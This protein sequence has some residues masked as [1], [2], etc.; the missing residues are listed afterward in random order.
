MAREIGN[1]AWMNLDDALIILRPENVEKRGILI[2]LANILRNFSP[3][4]PYTLYGEKTENK[5][6][7]QQEEYVFVCRNTKPTSRGDRRNRT[8]NTHNDTRSSTNYFSGGATRE[9]VGTNYT[10]RTRKCDCNSGS[11]TSST[12][13]INNTYVTP[14]SCSDCSKKA[15]QIKNDSKDLSATTYEFIDE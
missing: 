10:S 7:E 5:E 15:I 14:G 9:R 1:L 12:D 3:V 6:V 8:F 11:S 4:V 13:T 2:H